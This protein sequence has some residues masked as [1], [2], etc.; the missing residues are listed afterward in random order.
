METAFGP[1]LIH[2]IN[3]YDI[4]IM[5]LIR[6]GYFSKV[7]VMGETIDTITLPGLETEVVITDIS[8][9]CVT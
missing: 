5:N 6:L 7:I 2:L 9:F 1:I 3:M 4:S 8:V